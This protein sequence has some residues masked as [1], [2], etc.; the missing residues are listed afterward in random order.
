ME[1]GYLVHRDVPDD[2]EVDTFVLMDEDVPESGYVLPRDVG[3]LLAEIARQPLH[4][5]A[6]HLE[7]S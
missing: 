5:F 2:G 7:V 4:R 1:R 3:G 6:D